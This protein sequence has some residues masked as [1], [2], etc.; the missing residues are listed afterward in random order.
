MVLAKPPDSKV[1]ITSKSLPKEKGLQRDQILEVRFLDGRHKTL[2]A[3]S[4]FHHR[5]LRS[6][7]LVGAICPTLGE[8]G[9]LLGLEVDD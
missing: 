6:S 8:T 4:R 7:A 9:R 1:K 3:T 5:F 2:R